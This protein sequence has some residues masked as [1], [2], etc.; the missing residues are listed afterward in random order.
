MIN[1]W[2]HAETIL[3]NSLKELKS[4]EKINFHDVIG[5]RL[6]IRDSISMLINR[7][8]GYWDYTDKYEL[9]W[10]SDD[11]LD[12]DDYEYSMYAIK[13]CVYNSIQALRDYLP[14]NIV[15]NTELQLFEKHLL[16]Q[17]VTDEFKQIIE[18]ELN[19]DAYRK[20]Y[21][22]S[23]ENFKKKYCPEKFWAAAIDILKETEKRIHGIINYKKE[24][25]LF[26][27]E[28]KKIP[29]VVSTDIK[30][31]LMTEVQR[32][33]PNRVLIIYDSNVRREYDLSNWISEFPVVE[34]VVSESTT[35]KSLPS[36]TH[37]LNY[38]EEV[39]VNA[40]SLVIIMGGGNV[41]NLGGM[42]AG[43]MLRGIPFIHVPTTLLAQVDS[44][45][46]AKQSVN[47]LLGKNR[48]GLF[49]NPESIFINPLFNNTLE[50]IHIISG[51]VES[52]KHGI[53]QS[54]KL[55]KNIKN[56][57]I[58]TI[59]LDKIGEII[60]T[61]IKL[62]LEYMITDPRENSPEQH[63]ELGH[64]IGHSLEQLSSETIPHGICVAFGMVAEAYFLC[65]RGF[66]SESVLNRYIETVKELVNHINIP[67][68][69]NVSD[70]AK[71]LFMD[72]NIPLVLLND[73][74]EPVSIKVFLDDE[75]INDFSKA[76]AYAKEVFSNEWL[77][78]RKRAYCE[79]T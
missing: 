44:S 74:Q 68:E 31:R 37:L 40:R 11:F 1:T 64:K 36:L 23:P 30:K 10:C 63:L 39:S 77:L 73:F 35:G 70:I 26:H 69:I 76:V 2:Q 21:V 12:F 29:I 78:S 28:N 22:V 38:S 18:F 13:W 45:I 71:W 48:F 27:Y 47:G 62:K 57:D 54:D 25:L 79:C 3:G 53:C 65:K 55:I 24:D 9:V 6:G 42:A 7:K 15:D 34:Y 60:Y 4:V 8:N 20:D 56:F 41:G 19:A 72:N 61:T 50:E 51:L 33:S 46:G 17:N 32:C 16:Q 5:C 49:H 43:L 66:L 59:P 58:E 14:L 75:A 52:L 67:S